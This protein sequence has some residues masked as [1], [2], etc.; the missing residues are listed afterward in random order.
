MKI[1]LS[2]SGINDHDH[3]KGLIERLGLLCP[4]GF[5]VP[6]M[7]RARL[8][9]DDPRIPDILGLF[10]VWGL[11]PRRDQTRPMDYETEYHVRRYR[12]YEDADF[13][14]LELLQL[15][16]KHVF[17]VHCPPGLMGIQKSDVK[18]GVHFARGL[19]GAPV[20]VPDRVKA[21]M[22]AGGLQGLLMQP[23]RL[24]AN[25]QVTIPSKELDWSVVGGPWWTVDSLV[26]LPP[27]SPYLQKVN[28]TT[29]ATFPRDVRAGV[30]FEPGFDDVERHYL[31]SELKK[32]EPFDV[33]CGWE[34]QGAVEI[35]VSKRFY[36]FCKSHMLKCAFRPVRIDEG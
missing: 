19:F 6:G 20:I 12:E 1:F 28:T 21:L 26:T 9:Q 34:S 4:E 10:T 32:L 8:P 5:E 17:H 3:P 31:R 15:W 7:F 16:P 2:I 11:K 22:E 35:I 33:A 25:T 24:L 27:V 30:L 13:E 29:G 36:D 18:K 14:G 23:L